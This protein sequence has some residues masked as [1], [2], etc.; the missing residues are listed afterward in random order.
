[1][2]DGIPIFF[3]SCGKENGHSWSKEKTLRGE[4]T[5]K[6]VNSPK[7]GAGRHALPKKFGSRLPAALYPFR[8][9]LRPPHLWVQSTTVSKT[10]SAYF[11]SR[12][13]R[14]ATHYPV[15]FL[16]YPRLSSFVPLG[17]GFSCPIPR[18][19]EGFPKGRDRSPAPLCH[20][21]VW[22]TG[23]VPHVSGG[24]LRGS[25]ELCESARHR[26]ALPCY[27]KS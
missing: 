14:F 25:R 2:R 4:L 19:R 3:S 17:V 22:G 6:A 26:R 8:P 21:G 7:A 23:G 12:A 15:R 9:E 10:E 1:M 16:L 27:P 18:L 5:G 20:E 13:F 11:Y 24:D